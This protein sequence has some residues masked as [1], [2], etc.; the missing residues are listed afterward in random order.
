MRACVDPAHKLQLQLKDLAAREKAI[1]AQL[2]ALNED[3]DCL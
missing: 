1:H 3:D 2:A